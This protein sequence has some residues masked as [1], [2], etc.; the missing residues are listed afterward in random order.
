[1]LKVIRAKVGWVW[2][3]R[4]VQDTD[5]A[6]PIEFIHYLSSSLVLCENVFPA[7]EKYQTTLQGN[8]QLGNIMNIIHWYVPRRGHY[9]YSQVNIVKGHYSL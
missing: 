8:A 9:Q 3:T 5:C 6:M 7:N 2:L 4:L 1:M